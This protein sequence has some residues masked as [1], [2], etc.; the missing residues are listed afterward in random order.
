MSPEQLREAIVRAAM[1]LM[2][3]YETVTTA[4]F[5]QAADI[6]EAT[7][8][9][10]FDDKDA[11]MEAC[12]AAIYTAVGAAL[13]PSR[14]LRELESISIDQPLAAR[15]VEAIEALD[16]YH[17]GIRTD[18]EALNA[19][20]LPPDTGTG[21]ERH[22]SVDRDEFRAASRLVESRE[23]IATL[24]EPD[25]EQLRLPAD[26]L[27]DAFLG[28]SLGATRTRHPDGTPLPARQVVELFLHGALTT[29]GPA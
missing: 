10:V 14:V 7:L 18:M 27:A 13:D 16:A 29:T 28:M 4:Q 3:D 24:L 23:L 2:A 15:L 22:R 12:M 26:V 5:A 20:F 6:D 19:S 17:V 9:R 8:L 21:G 25:Q 1:P 11:V